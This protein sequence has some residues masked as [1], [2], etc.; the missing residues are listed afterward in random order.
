[1]WLR[2]PGSRRSAGGDP[3]TAGTVT[4]RAAAAGYGNGEVWLDGRRREAVCGR[5]PRAGQSGWDRR[6]AAV[7]EPAEAEATWVKQGRRGGADDEA[8]AEPE[9]GDPA[10]ARV[11]CGAGRG[12][13]ADA[14][15]RPVQATRNP[16]GEAGVGASQPGCRK[17]V[18]AEPDGHARP[19]TGGEAAQPGRR[20]AA[21]LPKL[22]SEPAAGRRPRRPRLRRRPG[23]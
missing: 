7:P 12:G 15:T 3:T 22:T 6:R 16:H 23:G 19:G 1:M 20:F 8:R 21:D 2:W 10:G 18:R 9:R 13:E 5:E 17:P 4:T 14:G 11:A